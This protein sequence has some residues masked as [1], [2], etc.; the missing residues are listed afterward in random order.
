MYPSVNTHESDSIFPT[1][2]E[3]AALLATTGDVDFNAHIRACATKQGLLLNEY[4][5]WKFVSSSAPAPSA[6]SSTAGGH[7]ELIASAN[8]TEILDSLGVGYVVPEKRNFS[9]LQDNGGKRR[10]H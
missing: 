8:E 5:L 6:E 9:F 2:S 4:G 1:L 10:K 7:W 3:G